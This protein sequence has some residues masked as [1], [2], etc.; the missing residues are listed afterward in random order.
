[1][2][3]RIV[4][5]A[6]S[7]ACIACGEK[8]KQAKD[9]VNALQGLA[10][11][12]ESMAA[13]SNEAQKFMDERRAK[14]DTVAMPY[15]DLQAFLP[16]SVSGYATD[17]GPTGQTMNMGAFSMTTIDQKYQSGAEPDVKRLHV[18]IADY[19]GSQA[20][21]AMMAPYMAM[22][23]SSEDDHHRTGTMKVDVPYTFG[24]EEF[25]K[26]T[27][28][29]KVMFGTRYRYFIT[30]EASGQKGDESKMVAEIATDIAKKLAGK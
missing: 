22:T 27:K 7:V 8:A 2:N 14:G 26:D 24:I 4:A 9:S 5:I 15:K 11:S 1:M 25:N 6:L 30:V 28:E 12:A 23:M 29:A 10:K 18:T 3:T 16:G 19:S 17:G 20:G 21:Y 13:S